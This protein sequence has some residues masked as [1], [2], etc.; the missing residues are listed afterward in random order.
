MRYSESEFSLRRHHSTGTTKYNRLV[1]KF[2]HAQIDSAGSGNL[3]HRI[4]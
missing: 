4:Q 2:G 1:H 3:E